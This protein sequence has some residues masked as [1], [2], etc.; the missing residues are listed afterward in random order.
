MLSLPSPSSSS[1]FPS[2][3][4]TSILTLCRPAAGVV[5]TS[6]TVILAPIFLLCRN[7]P[8]TIAD[9]LL[10]VPDIPLL[11]LRVLQTSH[12]SDV[13]L[14]ALHALEPS[15]HLQSEC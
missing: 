2:I 12:Q 8:K 7:N 4:T 6:I 9:E 13:S 5:V 3:N 10:L 14:F 11:T 15:S 1:S